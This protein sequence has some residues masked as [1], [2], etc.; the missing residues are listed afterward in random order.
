LWY[1]RTNCM[2]GKIQQLTRRICIMMVTGLLAVFLAV[3][4]A[5]ESPQGTTWHVRAQQL[6]WLLLAAVS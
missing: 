2:D 1:T 6:Q 4:L 3:F 5:V